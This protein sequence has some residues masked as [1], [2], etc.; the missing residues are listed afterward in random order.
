MSKQETKATTD[1]VQL[2]VFNQNAEKII[3][4][5]GGLHIMDRAPYMALLAAAEAAL[6][7]PAQGDIMRRS[8]LEEIAVGFAMRHLYARAQSDAALAENDRKE[9]QRI[10]GIQREQEIWR[11]AKTGTRIIRSCSC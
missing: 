6:A 7:D 2:P 10:F 3:P 9:K 11:S 8:A 5:S 4:P 1:F